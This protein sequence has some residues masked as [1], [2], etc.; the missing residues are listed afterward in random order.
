MFKKT[1]LGIMIIYCLG[2]VFWAPV[3]MA[4]ISLEWYWM[5]L[6]SRKYDE[7]AHKSWII[8]LGKDSIYYRMRY[9]NLMFWCKQF[10]HCRDN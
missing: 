3:N 10:E 6:W 1:L 8:P 5:S 4:G 2:F 7:V 9:N